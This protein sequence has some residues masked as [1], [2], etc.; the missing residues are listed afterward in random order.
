MSGLEH[1]GDSQIQVSLAR[2]MGQKMA[3]DVIQSIHK[4]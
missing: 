3:R 2:D 4:S 1:Q